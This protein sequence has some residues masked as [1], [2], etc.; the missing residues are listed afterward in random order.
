MYSSLSAWKDHLYRARDSV[1]T[2]NGALKR[3]IKARKLLEKKA[4]ATP[5]HIVSLPEFLSRI[6]VI[7]KKTNVI[8]HELVPDKDHKIRFNLR[9]IEDYYKFVK[10]LS[11]L[12]SLN[13]S[14]HDIEVHPYDLSKSPPLH[15]ITF[16]LT[17]REDAKPLSNDRLTS[18]MQRVEMK[19]R[20]NP[21][22]RFAY[23]AKQNLISAEIDLTWVYKLSGI[24]KIGN[25]RYATIENKDY[26][27][28]DILEGM[29]LVDVQ[30]DRVLLKKKTANGIE[31]YQLKFRRKNKDSDVRSGNRRRR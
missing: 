22:Q 1:R 21:F 7:S 20:R 24:G 6:N 18:L 12:E 14:I 15:V 2:E 30:A 19:D 17:P 28:G 9:I 10:F 13:V 3:V 16:A 27:A 8:I 11:T 26:S 25:T 31:K 5:Y 4:Q 29:K 23:N